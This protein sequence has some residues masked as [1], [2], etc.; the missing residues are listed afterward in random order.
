MKNDGSWSGSPSRIAIVTPV[1]RHSVLVMDA[2]ASV[3][4][5]EGFDRVDY[6]LV[7]D[8]CPFEQTILNCAALPT[9]FRNI[10]YLRTTNQ[11]LSA[12]R[13]TG[14]EYCLENFQDCESIFLLD[15][16][17]RLRPG[18]VMR[19]SDALTEHP[20]ADWF[21]P[22]IDMFGIPRK[23]DYSGEFRILTEVVMNICEAGSLV[24]RRVFENSLRY[25]E[26][27]KIG[28]EDWD[29]W[30][31]AIER[32]F[33]G[34][35]LPRAGFEYRKRAE[36]ML[37]N[38][39]RRHDEIMAY[40]EK[41]HPWTTN[42][43]ALVALEDRDAPR[44]VIFLVDDKTVKL[45][46]DPD[47]GHEMPIEEYGELLRDSVSRPNWSA[48]GA[49]VIFTT[50]EALDHLSR[51]GLIHFVFWRLELDLDKLESSAW[52]F[53]K[54]ATRSI[55][56]VEELASEETA[57]ELFGVSMNKMRDALTC[58][59]EKDWLSDIFLN[60]GDPVRVLCAPGV[61]EPSPAHKGMHAELCEFIEREK[62][63]GG[64][65]PLWSGRPTGRGEGTPDLALLHL[66]LRDRI[67]G[68]LHNRAT[69]QDG[70]VAFVFSVFEFG[71]VER[72][73]FQVASEFVAN[74]FVVDCI[75]IGARSLKMPVGFEHVFRSVFVLDVPVNDLWE[76]AVFM[77]TPLPT[78]WDWK[79]PEITNLLSGYEVVINCHCHGIL[80]AASQ[81]KK[82]GA[83]IV[84]YL[85]LFEQR[86]LRAIWGAPFIAM[87]FEHSIDIFACCSVKLGHE[88]GALGVP[89]HKIIPIP[90]G[91]GISI[92][93]HF[94]EASL[95]ERDAR[96]L[97][98]PTLRVLYL[99]R[100]DEQKGLHELDALV[101]LL[102][103]MIDS[104]T[105]RAVGGQVILN[106]WEKPSDKLLALAEPPV[107][108]ELEICELY[109]WADVLVLPSMFE[110]LP[111]VLIE[112]MTL[113]VVP[114]ATDVGAISEVL[115]HQEN[116]LLVDSRD[117][118]PAMMA[119]I[120]ALHQDRELLGRLSARAAQTGS[121]CD[122]AK[123]T[124]SL[125]EA[126]RKK[127]K[128]ETLAPPFLSVQT[129]A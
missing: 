38:S 18:S 87:A 114:I 61:S 120:M 14:I 64:F 96:R 128:S 95:R 109:Q 94:V 47:A 71:G 89:R 2:V 107:F 122:W 125:I 66:R 45:C 16:D 21:Y 33:R 30:L 53:R 59:S 67:G 75:V 98:E 97:M 15:A 13:N 121:E 106:K 77:G 82:S 129:D 19:F 112:A 28:Y 44:Y 85:H 65:A 103:G 43:N 40:L 80:Y 23:S 34:R 105:F 91:A 5:Q 42:I 124:Q 24:R 4:H 8:G 22:D 84:N 62:A 110:G 102:D 52:T 123:S 68:M 20:D 25:D 70:T 56:L 54:H 6:V 63:A 11:G 74:G 12:A 9:K 46:S 1:F 81:L 101:H 17:N 86:K 55:E 10:H 92:P 126:I 83:L 108:D 127:R 26:N 39:I 116:G 32:G 79:Y 58:G 37:S 3:V 88:L 104:I 7:D 73:G 51:A 27:M 31:S 119:N 35:H 115:V 93:P 111:L 90:N 69:P 36:S 76:G 49:F 118:A 60:A 48:A 57:I 100:L 78:S 41:K 117:V 99:G 113:G 50:R 29:F 72:V